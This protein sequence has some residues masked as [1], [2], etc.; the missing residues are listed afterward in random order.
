MSD[1]SRGGVDSFENRLSRF[2]GGRG[3]AL[4]LAAEWSKEAAEVAARM[5]EDAL[6]LEREYP[7]PKVAEALRLQLFEKAVVIR[8]P[9]EPWPP[10]AYTPPHPLLAETVRR[11]G[12]RPE[13]TRGLR[14]LFLALEWPAIRVQWRQDHAAHLAARRYLERAA[15]EKDDALAKEEASATRLEHAIQEAL[16]HAREALRL[17]W[18]GTWVERERDGMAE[19]DAL[20]AEY[21]RT[22]WPDLES[23]REF[24]EKAQKRL[25]RYRTSP[26]MDLGDGLRPPSPWNQDTRDAA[27]ALARILWNGKVRQAIEHEHANP[28]VLPV[29]LVH[30]LAETYWAVGRQLELIDGR[31][32][33]KKDGEEVAEV[34]LLDPADFDAMQRGAE[35]LRSVTGQRLVRYI[36]SEAYKLHRLSPGRNELVVEGGFSGLAEALGERSKKAAEVVRDVLR[37]GVRYERQWAGARE[38]SGLWTYMF[39][40]QEAKNRRSILTITV[41]RALRPY[42]ALS[43]LKPGER[44]GVPVLPMPPFVGNR[45]NE[46]AAQA[47]FQ[48]LLETALVERRMELLEYGGALL[49]QKDFEVLAARAG[50][51]PGSWRKVLDR[52][53]QDGDDGDA[54]LERIGENRYNLSNRAPYQAARAWILGGA[55]VSAAGRERQAKAKKAGTR[56]RGQRNPKGGGA[57]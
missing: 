50:L 20:L 52:W 3:E 33:L 44:F 28:L 21:A 34:A 19:P 6:R 25:T 37:A 22:R 49:E 27:G 53:T 17:P 57:A 36:A 16:D 55:K 7:A 4:E 40:A 23:V 30:E 10:E 1:Q 5:T 39:E 9:P 56:R 31:A 13:D 26:E 2:A 11:V 24:R 32:V 38:F 43:N 54:M 48:F 29:T 14:E 12:V 47:A 35:R 45:R 15:R 8:L 41:G 46:W 51:Y 42:V 18:N